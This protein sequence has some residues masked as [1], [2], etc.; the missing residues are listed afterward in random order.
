MQRHAFHC[1][2]QNTEDRRRTNQLHAATY[3]WQWY[4]FLFC[5]LTSMSFWSNVEVQV[6]LLT[7]RFIWRVLMSI[8]D[9][10]CSL[11]GLVFSKWN[12]CSVEQK[13]GVCL[14]QWGTL[15]CLASRTPWAP[16]LGSALCLCGRWGVQS[17][18]RQAE[19][20]TLGYSTPREWLSPL[21]A[22][23]LL[24]GSCIGGCFVCLKRLQRKLCH[25]KQ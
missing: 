23:W 24:R 17:Q 8:L 19:L 21:L 15:N 9:A 2:W 10:K 11:F 20:F 1:I 5:S 16:W 4:I 6:Q 3:V 14:F 13:L 22:E 25:I 12:T 18:K 7:S